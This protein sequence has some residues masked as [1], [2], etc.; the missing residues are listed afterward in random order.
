[1][2]RG[3]NIK[4]AIT[5]RKI[6]PINLSLNINHQIEALIKFKITR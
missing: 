5:Q 2:T 1:M 6:N 3:L 4:I